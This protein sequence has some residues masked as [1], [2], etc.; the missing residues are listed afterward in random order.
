MSSAQQYL[1]ENIVARLTRNTTAISNKDSVHK[2]KN[3]STE[4]QVIDIS[5]FMSGLGNDSSS[6]YQTPGSKKSTQK[7]NTET[8]KSNAKGFEDF[9]DRQQKSILQKK[10]YFKE[11]LKND[12]Y[13]IIIIIIN[14]YY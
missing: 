1:S 6:Q 10:K 14:N 2:K 7:L 12:F 3:D 9:M 5:S 13:F 11:V 8:P 4:R